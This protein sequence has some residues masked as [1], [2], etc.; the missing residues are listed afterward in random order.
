[1]SIT[2]FQRTICQLISESR[3]KSGASYIAGGVSLNSLMNS[4][5]ISND[6][7]IF[8]DTYDALQSGWE[9][10]KYLLEANKYEIRMVR[11]RSTFIE[12]IV[13]KDA[14]DVILQWTCDSAFRFFPLVEHE[15]FG[16][17]LHPVDLAT[18]KTLALVGRLEVRDWIDMLSSHEKIQHLGLLAWAACG[19]DPGFTPM[20]ILDEAAKSGHYSNAEVRS[21]IFE[22][23]V[24]DASE[25]A[26]KWKV[27][28]NEAR[29][30][31][32]ALPASEI[33]KCVLNRNFELLAGSFNEIMNAIGNGGYSF[34]EG[35]IHGA[36][37]T[38][39]ESTTNRH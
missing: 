26:R 18:N 39:K 24:P 19:K 12:A 22:N 28:L 36:F 13:S 30:I 11:E 6:I 20:L 7:D 8:N 16:L 31:I 10:D 9:N 23:S 35:S 34:H 15:Y 14:E 3:K 27:A 1:M 5:R 38:I 21:L 32:D 2:E 37:P 4:T 33:G 29:Q 25:L 17:T